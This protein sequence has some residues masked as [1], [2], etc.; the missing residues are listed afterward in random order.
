MAYVKVALEDEDY[1]FLFVRNPKTHFGMRRLGAL[2]G[3]FHEFADASSVGHACQSLQ[4]R[5]DEPFGKHALSS[6]LRRQVHVAHEAV[7]KSARRYRV[8]F[9]VT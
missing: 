5:Q 1:R 2:V 7:M 4:L 8:T 6:A 3:R 9:G